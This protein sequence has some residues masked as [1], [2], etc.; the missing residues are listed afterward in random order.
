M[1]Y[2]VAMP[3]TH[4]YNGLAPGEAIQCSQWRPAAVGRA[5]TRMR[6]GAGHLQYSV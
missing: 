4:V 5:D 6:H 3:F 2:Y 1:I